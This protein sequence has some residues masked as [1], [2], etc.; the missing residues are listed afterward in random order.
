ML[1]V[2]TIFRIQRDKRP[3]RTTSAFVCI[4]RIYATKTERSRVAFSDFFRE[5]RADLFFVVESHIV[6]LDC[7]NDS[8]ISFD[9]P[10]A[11]T[12]N[13][14]NRIRPL[15][16]YPHAMLRSDGML[17]KSSYAQLLLRVWQASGHSFPSPAR[18][19]CGPRSAFANRSAGPD[20]AGDAKVG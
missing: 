1:G 6:L 20:D 16:A 4:R 17:D 11:I 14:T 18:P 13:E 19:Q 10:R 2:A 7:R 8:K 12:R 15:L 5:Q 9:T 3:C